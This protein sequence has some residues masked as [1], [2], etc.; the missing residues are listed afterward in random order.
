[1]CTTSTTVGDWPDYSL[2]QS[3]EHWG[4]KSQ[5]GNGGANEDDEG[6]TLRE[7][8]KSAGGVEKPRD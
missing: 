4:R 8:T 7:A 6:E 3:G 2:A 5:A 1:M